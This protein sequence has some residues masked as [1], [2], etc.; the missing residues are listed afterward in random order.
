MNAIRMLLMFTTLGLMTGLATANQSKY[1]NFKVFLDDKEIGQHTFVVSPR[2]KQIAV[3]SEARFDVKFW[4]ISA[5][6]Y[7]HTSNEIWQGDCLHTIEA[8]TDDNGDSLFVRGSQKDQSLQLQTHAGN[9]TL[10]GC[11]RTFA[12]WNPALLS[13]THL[14]NVQTGK[15]EPVTFRLLGEAAIT[16]RDQAVTALHYRIENPGFS[17]DL[18]YSRTQEW[19]ALESTTESGARLRYLAL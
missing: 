15:L 13:S 3:T 8:S 9:K 4:F 17:I 16:V 6:S 19:L 12:Y 2:N 18:W 10:Q 14:L 5:Y 11:I 7:L 1:F